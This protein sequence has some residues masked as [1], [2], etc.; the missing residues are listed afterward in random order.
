L[1]K[2][3]LAITKWWANGPDEKE[4]MAQILTKGPDGNAR[5]LHLLDTAEMLNYSVCL[6]LHYLN[7]LL[8]WN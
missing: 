7:A 5:I 8:Q 2:L 6:A 4:G 1:E 3:V